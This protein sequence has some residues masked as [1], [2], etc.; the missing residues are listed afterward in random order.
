VTGS[1]VIWHDVE[2]GSYDADLPLWRQLADATGGPILDLGAG[3][4]RV[5]VDLTAQGHD[6][7]ALDSDPELLA[8]LS[9]REPSVRTVHADAREFSV[10]AQFP[11][12]IAPM[13]LVQILG[14]HRGRVA[15]LRRVHA[16]LFPTG[17][18][19]AAISDPSDAVPEELIPPPLPDILERD[20]WVYS[21]QPLTM[22]EQDGH[23]VIERRRQAVSPTGEIQEEDVRIEV[24][25]V[26]LDQFEAEAREAGLRP[27]ARKTIPETLEHI[28]STVV[29]CRR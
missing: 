6:V 27:V 13:S 19:A 5:S 10:D 16:H 18:F 28:G 12:V 25:V 14:G 20:G 17:L 22:Y 1:G 21:S 15:M 8:E 26:G 29:L 7:V 9:E 24:G 3:T 11:L 23:V 2:H 4:G